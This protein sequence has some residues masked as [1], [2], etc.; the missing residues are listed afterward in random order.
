MTML[1]IFLVRD[2]LKSADGDEAVIDSYAMD[3]PLAVTLPLASAAVTTGARIVRIVAAIEVDPARGLDTYFTCSKA[4][5]RVS[6]ELD[7][8]QYLRVS[9]EGAVQRCRT[10]LP[11]NA[12]PWRN[13]TEMA[14]P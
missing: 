1:T 10:T 2:E 8:D 11:L 12:K 5:R 14:K 4:A 13:E 6:G 7:F 9:A 3:G